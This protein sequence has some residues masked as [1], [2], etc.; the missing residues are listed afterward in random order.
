VW[1]R[2]CYFEGA[3]DPSSGQSVGAYLNDGVPK[4]IEHCVFW[5]NSVSEPGNSGAGLRAGGPAKIRNNTFV[6]NRGMSPLFGGGSVVLTAHSG[7]EFLNNVI[8][9]SEGGPA[10]HLVSGTVLGG[11]NVFW[12]NLEGNAFGY[13][14]QPTDREIDPLFCKPLIGDF[15][16]DAKS[17]CLPPYSLGCDLIG[18]L[19]EGCGSISVQ[20]HSWGKIKA[21]YRGD[22]NGGS[23]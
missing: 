21:S 23:Q 16:V 8:T 1:V 11:C 2:G 13:T 6:A 19:G 9:D 14:L 20:P 10:F 3:D 22:R 17:P 7:A 12:N 15:T 5:K 18:A 4:T